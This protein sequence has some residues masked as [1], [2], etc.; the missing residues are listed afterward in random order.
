MTRALRDASAARLRRVL[1]FSRTQ[2][3]G[4]ET[5]AGFRYSSIRLSGPQVRAKKSFDVSCWAGA[6]SERERFPALG[7]CPGMTDRE[8]IEDV[9]RK[10]MR[11]G[12]A[13]L[14]YAQWL[15]YTVPYH[16]TRTTAQPIIATLPSAG[17]IPFRLNPATPTRTPDR[18]NQSF[19]LE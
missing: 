13:A 9:L 6:C 19:R 4:S 14:S 2:V 15:E 5:R 8:V 12:K 7:V 16:G 1:E 10:E 17:A 11:T 18:S 3:M